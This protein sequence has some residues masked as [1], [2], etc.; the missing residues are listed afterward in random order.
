MRLLTLIALNLGHAA[1]EVR[2]VVGAARAGVHGNLW[3]R[4]QWTRARHDVACDER[5]DD[6]VRGF[7][8]LDPVFQRRQ[9]VERV[10][11]GTAAAVLHP[12]DHEEAREL[13]HVL[14]RLVSGLLP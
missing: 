3:I 8:L 9:H 10:W 12:G 2:R 1:N 14:A 4:A 5:R 7:A 13:L 11:S 6:P